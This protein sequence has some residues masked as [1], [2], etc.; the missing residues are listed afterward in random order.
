MSQCR[1]EDGV[2]SQ[3][4]PLRLTVYIPDFSR[5]PSERHWQERDRFISIDFCSFGPSNSAVS[6]FF[7]VVERAAD[8]IIDLFATEA[9]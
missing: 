8:F 5:A 6:S 2:E 4:V 1:E 3:D 9:L 7:A